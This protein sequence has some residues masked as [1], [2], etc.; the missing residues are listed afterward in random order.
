MSGPTELL[1]FHAVIKLD[2]KVDFNQLRVS[3]LKQ[4][5][6]DRGVDTSD[7]I[8]KTDFVNKVHKLAATAL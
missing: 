5:L 3:Q 6:K 8:E 7:C 4:L 1:L 2:P